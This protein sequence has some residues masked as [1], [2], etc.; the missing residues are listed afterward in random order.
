M[1]P[2]AQIWSVGTSGKL[3]P[4]TVPQLL[5]GHRGVGVNTILSAASTAGL[6]V[7][8]ASCHPYKIFLRYPPRAY[9]VSVPDPVEPPRR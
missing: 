2:E 1:S 6:A 9:E 5:V 4:L 8:S 3:V 7:A